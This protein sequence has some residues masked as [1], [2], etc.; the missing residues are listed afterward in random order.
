MLT[1][2]EGGGFSPSLFLY[3]DLMK[4]NHK[5]R[6]SVFHVLW[7]F[8]YLCPRFLSSY[9]CYSRKISLDTFSDVENPRRRYMRYGSSSD[10]LSGNADFNIISYGSK[11]PFTPCSTSHPR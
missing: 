6:Q 2:S 3:R 11:A 8:M 4:S 7:L 10:S 5:T 1:K 9:F